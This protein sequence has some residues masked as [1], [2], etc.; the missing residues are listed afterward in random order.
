VATHIG[1][2]QTDCASAWLCRLD[3]DAEPHAG[4]IIT[5]HQWLTEN[6]LFMKDN[7]QVLGYNRNTTLIMHCNI[8]CIS[9]PDRPHKNYRLARCSQAVLW[10]CCNATILLFYRGNNHDGKY[11]Y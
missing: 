8:C 5:K 6:R 2:P 11:R 3:L 1:G 4:G 9:D 7:E 10:N